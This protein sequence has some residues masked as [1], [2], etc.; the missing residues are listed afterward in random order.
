MVAPATYP[1]EYEPPRHETRPHAPQ[2]SQARRRRSSIKLSSP[3]PILDNIAD[4]ITNFIE[5]LRKP[6]KM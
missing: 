5:G 6:E 2:A 3:G 1:E 4:A